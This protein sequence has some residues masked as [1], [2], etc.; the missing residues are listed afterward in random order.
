MSGFNQFAPYLKKN[1]CFIVKNITEFDNRKKV[2]RIFDY[3]ININCERDLLM[4][5]GVSEESIQ[6]SLFKGEI[7]HKICAKDIIIV[8]SNINLLQFDDAEKA[9][10]QSAGIVEGLEVIG[11]GRVPYLW[12]EEKDLIGL[13]NNS[14]RTFYTSEKFLNGTFVT[15]DQFHIHIKH[16]GKDLYEGIDYTIAESSGPG[17]GYDI[18][19]LISFTPVPHSLFKATYAVKA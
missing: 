15:G 11:V 3:P 1:K 16:N 18:I 19:N 9:F 8:C 14:N 7:R 5:P 13:K 4:I 17:T 12:R 6:A 10:L 2:I